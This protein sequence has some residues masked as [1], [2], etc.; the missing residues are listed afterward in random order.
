MPSERHTEIFLNINFTWN[1]CL[2]MLRI[3]K[4]LVIVSNIKFSAGAK[5]E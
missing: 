5:L 3:F 1:S 4:T 2:K